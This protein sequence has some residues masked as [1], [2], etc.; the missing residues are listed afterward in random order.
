MAKLEITLSPFLMCFTSGP[1]SSTIPM[2]YRTIAV[3]QLGRYMFVM[4]TED[5][6]ND[7]AAYLVSQDISGLHAGHCVDVQVKVGAAD[8]GGRHLE[9]SIRLYTAYSLN[10][11]G[12]PQPSRACIIRI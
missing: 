4:R 8:S 9:Q 2:N 10:Y 6:S 11:E 1:T 12:V 5:K 7:C 3:T